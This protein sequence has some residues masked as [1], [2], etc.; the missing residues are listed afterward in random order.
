M[1]GITEYGGTVAAMKERAREHAAQRHDEPRV[2][3][4][5]KSKRSIIASV[6]RALSRGT[7]GLGPSVLRHLAAVYADHPDYRPEWRP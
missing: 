3:A 4:E 2:R 5:C 7:N 6:D 1:S